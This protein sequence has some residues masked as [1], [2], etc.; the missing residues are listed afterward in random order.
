MRSPL[1]VLVAALGCLAVGGILY[2][3]PPLMDAPI[4]S[5]A[6]DPTRDPGP[7]SWEAGFSTPERTLSPSDFS[8]LFDRAVGETVVLPVGGGPGGRVNL[9]QD[10]PGGE[11]V[12]GVDFGKALDATAFL[13]LGPAGTIEGHLISRRLGSALVF[14]TDPA[15]GRVKVKQARA[16]DLICARFEDGGLRPGMPPEPPGPL[17]AEG[18]PGGVSGPEESIPDLRSRPGS[19]RVIYLDF[20]GETISGTPW[21]SAYNDGQ[22]IVAAA[23]ATPAHI[24]GIWETIAEDYAVFEVNVTTVRADFD[25]APP[26][27]RV[28][29]IFTPSKAWYGSAGGV[30]Y[31]NSFGSPTNPYCWVFNQTLN[32]AAESG[33]HEIGHTVGLRHDGTSSRAYYTGHTHPS[34]VSWAPIMGTGYGRTIVQFSK[35]EY[36]GANRPEDDLAIISGKLPYLPDDHG[37]SPATASEVS[38]SG[39]V[40]ETGRIGNAT[41]ADCFR[42]VSTGPGSISVTA[43]PHPR[44]RNLDIAL[45]LLD[46]AFEVIAAAVPAGPFDAAITAP[47]GAGV[48]YVRVTGSGLGD[49]ISGYGRYGSIG[50]Y[51]LEGTYPGE[52]LPE[53]PAGFTATDGTSTT[54]VA[55]SWDAVPEADGYRIERGLSEDGSD[56]TLLA[57]PTGTTFDDGTAVPGTVYWY[58]VRARKGA[59]ESPRSPGESGWRQLEPPAAPVSVTAG[60]DSPHSIRVSWAAA[61]RAQGYR[62][63]RNPANTSAGATEI[64]TTTSLSWHDTT[65]AVNDPHYYFVEAVNTGGTSAAV[66]S[67]TPGVRIPLPPGTPTGFA[68]SDGSSSS[69]T[70][71]TWPAVS[72]ATGY[73]L[74]RHTTDSTEGAVEIATVGETT[75]HGD[76]GGV[77]GTLY[78]YFVRAILAGGDSAP[79]NFDTGFRTAVAPSP[80]GAVSATLGTRADGVLV[81][82]SAAADA[83]TYRVYRGDGASPETAELI[84]ETTATEWLDPDPVAGRTHRYFV[85]AVNP[86]GSSDYSAAALGHGTTPD[87]FDDRFENNDDPSLAT[88]MPGET[89]RAVAVDGDPDWYEVVLAAGVSRLDVMVIG[90]AAAGAVVLALHD[91]AGAPLAPVE[92]NRGAKTISH[93]GAP[94]A[95]YRILVE[96]DEGAAVPYELIARPVAD[97]ETGLSADGVIGA[98]FPPA[99]GEGLVESRAAGQSLR[100]PVKAGRSRR[101]YLDLVN[102]SAVEGGFVARGGAGT[103]RI[104]LDHYRWEA[105]RWL[106]VTATVRGT[107]LTSSL[108]PFERVHLQSTARVETS[109]TGRTP[110]F[111]TTYSFY[112]AA[113]PSARDELRWKLKPVSRRR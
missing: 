104:S 51:T 98:A 25:A 15:D 84:G 42:I 68:A 17:A 61:E 52:P 2:L 109:R 48:H 100:T 7:G 74:Y 70:L 111:R 106:R 43:A 105:G 32:G 108:A 60:D 13:S 34:G 40:N 4:G 95:L 21:N 85:S 86:V 83:A 63:S 112:P 45:E 64:A 19:S 72:G 38:P 3:S 55:L 75:S 69:V 14:S 1:P 76:S 56:A 107:G 49:P 54:A 97:G 46:D 33:S 113:D 5:E 30:A 27:Q 93:T 71:L 73:R 79:G 80:P 36:A 12:L 53:A 16:E 91:E 41:D 11:R 82:W 87:P 23:F 31:V 28:M 81:T 88:P 6:R 92:E 66:A 110:E 26:S 20:D 101:A 57:S 78:W 10:L 96:R 44:Y 99:L 62:I 102:R 47:V 65:T 103:R 89:I 29:V 39:I 58:F 35:G 50:T 59:L 94:G 9:R 37:D 18:D 8:R 22:P 90:D 67:P 24:E 77:P